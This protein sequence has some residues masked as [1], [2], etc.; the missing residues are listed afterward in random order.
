M[1]FAIL[2]P[3]FVIPIVVENAAERRMYLP[4]LAVLVLLVV[5]IKQISEPMFRGELRTQNSAANRNRAS[6]F[7]VWSGLVL[8]MTLG[9]VS[10][11]R[12]A[13]YYDE[14]R[15]WREVLEV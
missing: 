13:A 11:K 3:T 14:G 4:L 5:F 12:A 10:Q 2:S 8:A 1:A 6:T 7:L 15:L 9:L